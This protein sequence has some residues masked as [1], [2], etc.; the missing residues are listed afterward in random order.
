MSSDISNAKVHPFFKFTSV[1]LLY[2]QRQAKIVFQF[3][4][5]HL[6]ICNLTF[7]FLNQSHSQGTFLNQYNKIIV[8]FFLNATNHILNRFVPCGKQH[9]IMIIPEFV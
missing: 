7:I 4:L 8:Q 2:F 5:T 1:P 3:Y 9:G 6:F